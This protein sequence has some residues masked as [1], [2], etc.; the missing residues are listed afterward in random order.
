VTYLAAWF[1]STGELHE[2]ICAPHSLTNIAKHAGP[3]AHAQVAMHMDA[4]GAVTIEITDDGG[5]A[6]ARSSQPPGRRGPNGPAGHGLI[7][8]RERVELLGG[9]LHA[10]P[11]GRGWRLIALLPAA[12]RE[13]RDW[14]ANAAAAL[15]P[16]SGERW[17]ARL[18]ASG[19]PTSTEVAKQP[20]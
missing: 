16:A 8:M 13:S 11:H 5:P 3:A 6:M 1:I 15:P 9:S 19:P 14:R 20:R 10:G 2:H 17:G 12:G 7:G 18:G 4:E